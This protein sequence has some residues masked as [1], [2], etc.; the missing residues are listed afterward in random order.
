M[1]APGTSLPA[2]TTE[3]DLVDLVAYAGATWDWHRLHHDLEFVRAQ[4]FD[5]PVVDGQVFGALMVEVLQDGLGPTAFVRELTF[6]LRAP[7]LAGRSVRTEAT[8]TAVDGD[9]AEV[10]LRVVL[11]PD[12]D[13]GD[14]VEA[15]VGTAR[16]A[17]TP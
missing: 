5:A 12:A 6:R 7:V 4:G 3:F 11:L 15:V 17:V 9:A 10:E 1:I 2:R 8:V 16:V 14:E 13:G